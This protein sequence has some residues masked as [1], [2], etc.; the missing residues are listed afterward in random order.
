MQHRYCC[1]AIDYMFR[2]IHD[3]DHPFGRA[4][5]VFSR[6]FCQILRVIVNGT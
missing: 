1:E 4:T 3:T 6:D 5:I 2:D